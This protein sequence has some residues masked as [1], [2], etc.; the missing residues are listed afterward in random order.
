MLATRLSLW[1]KGNISVN[2]GREG[3]GREGASHA[4]IYIGS[5]TKNSQ[6]KK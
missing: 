4:E 3:G 1:A 2:K 6:K 5:I